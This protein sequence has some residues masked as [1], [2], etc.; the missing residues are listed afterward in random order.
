MRKHK[1]TE[2]GGSEKV[3]QQ[4]ADSE[5][6]HCRKKWSAKRQ[7][8]IAGVSKSTAGNL[9]VLRLLETCVVFVSQI[10]LPDV[11]STFYFSHAP[12]DS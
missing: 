11:T 4:N 9:I 7:I 5:N 1:K 6:K 3:S 12:P 8:S 2:K 10:L